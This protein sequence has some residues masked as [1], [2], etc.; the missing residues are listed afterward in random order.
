M[1][2]EINDDPVPSLEIWAV[3]AQE[4]GQKAPERTTLK[5]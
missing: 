1:S 3:D 4:K 5:F 2:H